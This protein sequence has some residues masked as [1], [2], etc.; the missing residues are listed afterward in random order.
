MNARQLIK[1]SFGAEDL[2]VI[3]AAFDKA[4]VEIAGNFGDDPGDVGRARHRLATALL[5]V[6]TEDNRDIEV[7]K[8]SALQRMAL[9][10]R[11]GSV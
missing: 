8:R 7:L 2:E 6:A 11:K 9:D 4:W 10:Y 5:S 1:D 3:N